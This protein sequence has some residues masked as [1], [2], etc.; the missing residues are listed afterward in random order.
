MPD[1]VIPRDG[2]GAEF[3]I[4]KHGIRGDKGAKYDAGAIGVAGAGCGVGVV[5]EV[6][7]GGGGRA[8]V[9]VLEYYSL[10][11]DSAVCAVFAQDHLLNLITCI[12]V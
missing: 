7:D 8:G 5:E 9:V 6:D 12:L 4:V 10:R 2:S 3:I 11:D 1:K